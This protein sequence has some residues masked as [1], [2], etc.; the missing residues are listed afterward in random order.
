LRSS[1]S[2]L[3]ATDVSLTAPAQTKGRIDKMAFKPNN[4]NFEQGIDRI[5][6]AIKKAGVKFAN[7]IV[8]SRN[9]RV[10]KVADLLAVKNIPDGFKK[11]QLPVYMDGPSQ[12]F[13]SIG[14]PDTNVPAHSHDE[15]DGLRVIIGGSIIYEGVE[16]T[17]GDWMFIPKGKKYQFKVGRGGASMFYCYQCCCA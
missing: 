17:E 12:M 14:A 1:S 2:R 6:A 7:Q 11:W 9:P 3:P 15:G 5:N 4:L 13:L 16:L 10:R 8:T